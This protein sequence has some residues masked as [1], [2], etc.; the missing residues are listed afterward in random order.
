[1][2]T[3]SRWVLRVVL[4]GVA[5]LVIAMPLKTMMG[6]PRVERIYH[7]DEVARFRPTGGHGLGQ[8]AGETFF[9]VLCAWGARRWMRVRL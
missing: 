2:I 7:Q 6:P 1:V 5:A 9:V 3:V 4:I 8:L